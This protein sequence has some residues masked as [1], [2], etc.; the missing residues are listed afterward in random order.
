MSLHLPE[1]T[2]NPDYLSVLAALN[3]MPDKAAKHLKSAF[4]LLTERT[5]TTLEASRAN[6]WLFTDSSRTTLRCIDMYNFA[7]NLHSSE[8]ELHIDQAPNYINAL[9][10]E[11][12]IR[13][14][15]AATDPRT[16]EFHE[17]YLS[18][19]N[20]KS[21]LDA[22]IR[23]DG[24]VVGV[25]CVEQIGSNRLWDD[26]EANF[27]ATMS[28]FAT[29]A[30]LS[31][32]KDLAETALIQSQKMESLGRLAGGIAHDF[33]NILMV[34]SGAVDT[35]Q[36]S[37]GEPE[38]RQ[39][40]LALM[41]DACERAQKLTRNL[42]AFGGKQN[43]DTQQISTHKLLHAIEG[44]TKG[45]IREDIQVHFVVGHT[46]FWFEGDQTKLEQV[47]L[48]LMIN[49][50]D[51]MPDGG[52]LTIEALPPD[53]NGLVGLA[54][55]DTGK[56]IAQ[57][58]VDR[59]FEPFF[60]TKGELGTGLGLSISS[61]IVQQHNGTLECVST[62]QDGTRFEIRVPRI[63]QRQVTDKNRRTESGSEDNRARLRIL[64]VEDEESV[65]DI[66][67]QM[68][69]AIGYDV[70][71]AR[72]AGHGLSL[73]GQGDI[74]L[75]VS[76]VIMPDMRGPDLYQSALIKQPDLKALFVSGYS[77]DLTTELTANSDNVGYL[78]KPFTLAQLRSA[79][80][81]LSQNQNNASSL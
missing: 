34:L 58:C 49:A 26:A 32:A 64:L 21:M 75:L 35:L 54:V 46:P 2:P 15:D 23:Q 57:D 45:I 78:S 3:K 36:I 50:M 42:L 38:L 60:S 31:H 25:I 7:T 52:E 19:H 74:D 13:A 11:R 24:E 29:M 28:D 37:G 5:A 16:A 67:S 69:S 65:R 9:K 55:V 4:A 20:I 48:N 80:G 71:V 53:H 77:E 61:G 14:D 40:M 30:L 59:I 18:T 43:L 76:D 33:N 6:V 10:H 22:P 12:V 62:S 81:K 8:G 39:R 72:S 1:H 70:Q 63:S 17:K 73:L 41:A 47:V 68:L 51:A 66:V 44:L 79:L 56:G 27:V